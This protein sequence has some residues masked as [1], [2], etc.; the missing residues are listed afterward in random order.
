MFSAN[1]SSREVELTAQDDEVIKGKLHESRSD[2]RTQTKF[3]G[4]DVG[5]GRRAFGDGFDGFLCYVAKALYVLC[6]EF[7]R[8]SYIFF[9]RLR[10]I[11]GLHRLDR[12]RRVRLN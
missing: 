1:F 7:F 9:F 4:D 6:N 8:V 11:D 5:L 3:F 10:W 12:Y 2:L